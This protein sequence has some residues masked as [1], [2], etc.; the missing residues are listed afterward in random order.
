LAGPHSWNPAYVVIAGAVGV[1]LIGVAGLVAVS[2]RS[3]QEPPQEG[4]EAAAPPEEPAEYASALERIQAGGEVRIG[5]DSY[6]P[7]GEVDSR[8]EASGFYPDLAEEVF[9]ELGAAE[10]ELEWV[11]SS[12]GSTTQER[13]AEGLF[14]A[15]VILGPYEEACSLA[16]VDP[17][18][19]TT[20]RLEAFLVAKDNPEGIEDY[21]DF[22]EGALTPGSHPIGN[23][24]EPAQ[25]DGVAEDQW[26]DAHA[27]QVPQ[28]LADGEIDGYVGDSV[29]LRWYLATDADFRGVEVTDPFPGRG[30][31]PRYTA[32]VYSSAEPELREAADEVLA[33]MRGGGR[34]GALGAKD[35]VA[36]GA[37]AAAGQTARPPCGEE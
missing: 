34:L 5:V 9:T 11:A 8:G 17:G 30:E 16:D 2:D 18:A 21:T 15:S 35:R 20:A 33:Q 13:L 22:A 29:R 32:F 25:A 37:R 24:R 14:D 26:A 19:P 7:Y 28:L 1:T 10:V 3:A 27:D 6:Q 31:P 23:E 36:A 12:L 4:G